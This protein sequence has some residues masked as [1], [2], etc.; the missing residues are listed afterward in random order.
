VSTPWSIADPGLRDAIRQSLARTGELLVFIRHNLGMREWWLVSDSDELE[1]ALARVS[2]NNGHSDAVEVYGTGEFPHR[3]TDTDQL[4]AKALEIV[5]ETDVV[6]ACKR[7]ED[8]E[9][10]DVEETDEV[11]VVDEWFREPH[12]GELL[13][14]RHPLLMHDEF[15]PEV[16]DA[17]LAY[18][19]L[20]DGAVR[21]G[22][23]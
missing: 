12:D 15:F 10:Q 3:G 16:A 20:P 21:P 1:R 2:H 13:V 11:E 14:G 4:K 18:G 5:Q 9:L 6:M 22:S 7:G 23:Y 17:Y 8:P 19:V